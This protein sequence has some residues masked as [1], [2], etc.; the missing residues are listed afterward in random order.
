MDA[1]FRRMTAM[2]GLLV[3]VQGWNRTSPSPTRY[4]AL[5]AAVLGLVDPLSSG[6]I[7][8]WHPADRQPH[9]QTSYRELEP[10]PLGAGTGWKSPLDFPL[11][12]TF[13]TG[14]GDK[15]TDAGLP[16]QLPLLRDS[17]SFV[18]RIS[19]VAGGARIRP[20]LTTESG[21]DV[22]HRLPTDWTTVTPSTGANCTGVP[23]RR[24]FELCA[25]RASPVVA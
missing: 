24:S 9:T 23:A 16:P 12:A 22:V 13:P 15:F 2:P 11:C 10:H 17:K 5:R 25:D 14:R 1:G 19:P 6:S 8:Q 4:W 3:S 18:K 20:Q 21:H 7:P